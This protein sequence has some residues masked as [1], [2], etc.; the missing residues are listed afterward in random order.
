MNQIK[1]LW[2][3][4]PVSTW[5][6]HTTTE[7]TFFNYLAGV[8]EPC[9]NKYQSG[10]PMV[11]YM[12]GDMEKLKNVKLVPE[13]SLMEVL[14]LTSKICRCDLELKKIWEYWKIKMRSLIS[15]SLHLK[16]RQKSLLLLC[17]IGMREMHPSCNVIR[18]VAVLVYLGRQFWLNI[19]DLY[20]L[21][22]NCEWVQWTYWSVQFEVFDQKLHCSDQFYF[23]KVEIQN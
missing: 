13:I 20:W 8:L 22:Q 14:F 5:S 23:Q 11:P 1:K 15:K 3:C 16:K 9:V 2:K 6:F 17:W 19:Y 10:K 4:S 12:Y 21:W 7:L 18:S